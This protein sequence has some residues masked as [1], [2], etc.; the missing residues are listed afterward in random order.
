MLKYTNLKSEGNHN[1][2]KKHC[3]ETRVTTRYHRMHHWRKI[4]SLGMVWVVDPLHTKA[5]G[6]LK[7]RLNLV[8]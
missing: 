2:G 7:R 4:K 6:N 8:T 3:R 5:N 1:T